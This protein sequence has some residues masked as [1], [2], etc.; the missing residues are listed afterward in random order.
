MDW[1]AQI[2]D[3]QHRRDVARRLLHNQDLKPEDR[4]ASLL[5]LLSA[6][7]SQR[8]VIRVG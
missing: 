4:L 3:Y 5:V 6:R 2:L 8:D 1:A 7:A